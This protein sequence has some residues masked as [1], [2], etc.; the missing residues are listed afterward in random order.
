MT[1]AKFWDFLTPL[2]RIW[3]GSTVLNSRNLPY[4][5]FFWANPLPPSVRTSYMD[6][7]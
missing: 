5:I 4:Y 7:P 1:P 2:V 3:D 6:A